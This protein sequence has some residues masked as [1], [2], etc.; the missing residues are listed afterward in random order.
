VLK[1]IQV[2]IDTFD[3]M[4]TQLTEEEIRFMAYWEENR[5]KQK[6]LL[7]QLVIGLPLGVIFA[8]PVLLNLFS[9][10]YKRANMEANAEL[11]PIVLVTAVILI[12]VFVAVFSRK[13]K[14]DMKEQYYRELDVKRQES[15]HNSES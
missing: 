11:N 4:K 2:R 6:K 10:W 15:E 9:G 14:W 5:L 1:K 8:V 13:H 7:N 12:I 3:A